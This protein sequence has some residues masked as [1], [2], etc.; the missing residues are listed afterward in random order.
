M[1]LN[2]VSQRKTWFAISAT[3][4][5]ASIVAIA[6][7]GLNFGID[8]TGGSLLEVE[9]VETFDVEEVRTRMT[10]A[11]YDSLSIQSSDGNGLIIRTTDLSE[12]EHQ[13]LL[14]S[15]NEQLGEVE[16]HR[17]DSIGPVIGN[18]LR[19]TA[20][21]GVV[22]TL[23]LIGLYIA[24][25]FR[26]VSEPVESWKYGVLTIMAAFHDVVI[27]LGSFAVIGHFYG[28]EIGT[29][30]V[31]AI[32]TILGYSINDTVVVF[33]RTR[34]NLTR[35]VGDTFEDTVSIS[36]KQTFMRSFNTS[37]TTLL[38]LLAIFLFGG[39]STKPFALALIIGIAV[40]TYS[41]LFLASPALVEW[42]KRSK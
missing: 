35:R 9:T 16:E 11:G 29:A 8:F 5:I 30:F 42:N 3:L 2:I 4:V 18:E 15:L 21:W 20:S 37:V 10:N 7:L 26:Q 39:D 19:R 17:F 36:L 13:A 32:L 25:A 31:A 14:T 24:W 22:I 6:T 38:A 41:S 23:L 1:K 12:E 40:G 28:W 33:D 27:V 34:E